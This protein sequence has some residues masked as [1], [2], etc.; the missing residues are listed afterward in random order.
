AGAAVLGIGMGVGVKWRFGSA[1][2]ATEAAAEPVRDPSAPRSTVAEGREIDRMVEISARPRPTLAE[3]NA[4]DPRARLGLL[5]RWLSAATAEEVASLAHAWFGESRA[6][7]T[8]QWHLVTLRW[9]DLDPMAAAAFGRAYTDRFLRT[10]VDW[11]SSGIAMNTPLDPVYRAWGK[12]DPDA[13]LASLAQEPRKYRKHLASGLGGMVDDERARAWA[14]AHPEL[15]E[16]AGWRADKSGAAQL[17]MSNPA[18]AAAELRPD[19][20]YFQAAHIAGE[21]MKSDPDAA[22]A[23]ARGLTD[24]KHRRHALQS[25]MHGF[26]ASDPARARPLIDELPAGLSRAQVEASYA[27][28][29]AKTDPEAALR[30]ATE[31]LRGTARLEAIAGIAAE[32]G[33]TDPLAAL[34]MLSDH[35]IGDFGVGA[36]NN[37]HVE[38]PH[39]AMGGSSG[40][41]AVSEVLKAAAALDPVGVMQLLADTGTLRPG[42]RD[43]SFGRDST[44]GNT[45]FSEWTARDTHAAARWLAGQPTSPGIISLAQL[46]ADRW[47]AHDVAGLQ[48]LATQ[49]A[50]GD[51]RDTVVAEAARRLVSADPA[52]ALSWAAQTGGESAF[53]VAFRHLAE[54][55]PQSAV[56]LYAESLTSPQQDAQRQTLTDQLARRSATDAIAFFESLPPEA[57]AGVK[58]HDTTRAYARQDPEAASEWIAALPPTA[59]KDTAISGLVE[60]LLSDAAEPDPVA[61]AHWAAAS[62]DPEGRNRRLQRVAEAWI[63]RNP[64]GFRTAIADSGL[65][66]NIQSAL[67]NHAPRPQ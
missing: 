39:T 34:K 43:G 21:W 7:G 44:L 33:K 16:F 36:L 48:S 26:L 11:D 12:R 49:F 61:A 13:A 65:P 22:L 24:S 18:K 37:V 66:P 40:V 31:S 55:D 25:V 57:Q 23:W 60:Y 4:A 9:V 15:H 10:T 45:L 14:L 59:A 64:T 62:P 53:S 29:L 17:D 30:H 56:A 47:P 63:R 3:L 35:G 20:P 8:T 51:A 28:V 52:G 19:A 38:G 27:A 50:P 46:T 6:G 41:G 54:S 5:I 67:L 42:N 1:F 2:P 32:K 58:L